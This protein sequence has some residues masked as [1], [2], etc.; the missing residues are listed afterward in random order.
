MGPNGVAYNDDGDALFSKTFHV[1]H[2][3]LDLVL[4][5]VRLA[6]SF[7]RCKSKTAFLQASVGIGIPVRLACCPDLECL[8]YFNHTTEVS[9]VRRQ[10]RR[11]R[12]TP[13]FRESANYEELELDYSSIGA[14]NNHPV[15]P[16]SL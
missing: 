6:F 14:S 1:S 5:L 10:L 15:T 12:S 3:V 16:A 8:L 7:V 4:Y 11:G 13:C 2:L 9:N